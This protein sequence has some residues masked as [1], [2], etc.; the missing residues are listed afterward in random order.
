[1]DWA[2]TVIARHRLVPDSGPWQEYYQ[3][4]P[5]LEAAGRKWVELQASQPGRTEIPPQDGLMAAAMYSTIHA[6]SAEDVV[7][8]QPAPH[9]IVIDP[10]RASEKIKGFARQLGADLVGIAPLN[11]AWIYSYTACSGHS[12]DP[13][14]TPIN[15]PHHHAISVA[16]HYKKDDLDCAPHFRVALA[17][18]GI[19]IRLSGMVVALAQYIRSLGYS[20]KAHTPFN[21]QVMDVP[22]AVDA[23]LGELSRSG[24]LITEEYG[25]NFKPMS[26]T[27]DM[28]LKHDIPV[29]IGVDEF[30]SRC[31]ICADVCPSG[32]IPRG[33]K[34]VIRG[35]RKWKL[36]ENAC[37][38]Y[39][40]YTGGNCS[41]C[42][43]YCPWTRPR[44]FPH[45][46]IVKAVEHSSIARIIAIK[47]D[48]VRSRRK[49]RKIPSWLDAYPEL[50][51]GRL[52]RNPL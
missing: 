16:V 20:A 37:F 18:L 38:E 7:D 44:T 50:W 40:L 47:A 10:G 14:R 3:K 22:I 2:D 46:V 32:A 43:A 28:P 25:S 4:H 34:R 35:V 39:W 29:D 21:T 24:I 27:T 5:E 15:L 42:M 31:R 23:G 8:G 41:L 11:Q 19:Y 48:T 45:N 33:D 13:M 36:N 12:G 6:M 51:K 30:C 52:K 1:M 17:T 49:K 9:R 26:V